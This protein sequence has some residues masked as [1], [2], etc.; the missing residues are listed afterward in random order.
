MPSLPTIIS[1]TLPLGGDSPL[2]RL[3]M[4]GIDAPSHCYHPRAGV[5]AVPRRLF[6]VR[7][8]FLA[9]LATTTAAAE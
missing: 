2:V 6:D 4:E 9:P 7:R 3:V 8:S 5:V 1:N